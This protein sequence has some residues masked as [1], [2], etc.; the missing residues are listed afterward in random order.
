MQVDAQVVHQLEI[1]ASCRPTNAHL[2]AATA[3][4]TGRFSQHLTDTPDRREG[5]K[6]RQEKADR[7]RWREEGGEERGERREQR[8]E[9]RKVNGREGEKKE[10]RERERERERKKKRKRKRNIEH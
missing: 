10:G 5:K 1:Q 4:P 7:R 3:C 8:E 6:G 9:G 2:H